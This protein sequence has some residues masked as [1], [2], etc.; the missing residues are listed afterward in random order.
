MLPHISINYEAVFVWVCAVTIAFLQYFLLGR[1]ES[2]TS[3]RKGEKIS[4]YVSVILSNFLISWTLPFGRLQTICLQSF[5]FAATRGYLG[6]SS[7]RNLDEG[8]E[9]ITP[10]VELE[11]YPNKESYQEQAVT[12][13]D[14]SSTGFPY[15]PLAEGQ[16]RLLRFLDKDLSDDATLQFELFHAKLSQRPQYVALS[17]SWG[18]SHEPR[19]VDIVVSGCSHE[20]TRNLVDAL[21]KLRENNISTVWVDAICIN[22]QDAIEKSREVTRMFA[23]YRTAQMVVIWL[24]LDTAP[25]KDMGDLSS[26]IEDIER[27]ASRLQHTP[28]STD[29]SALD[30]LLM[31]PYW[32][33]VWIIQETA[34]AK[35]AR[36]FWGSYIFDLR[37]LETLLRDKPGSGNDHPLHDLARRVLSVRAACRAQQKP[38]LMDI[39]AMTASSSTSVLRDKVYGL[40]GL[41]SDWTDF[42]QEPNYTKEVSENHLCLE[43]TSNHIAWYSSADII[44][45]RSTNRYQAELPSWC[46]DY[47]HFQPHQFDKNLIPYVCGQD[48]NLGWERRRAFGQSSPNMNEIIPDTFVT[49]GSRLI[50]KGRRIGQITA[51]G[52]LLDEEA[53]PH[54]SHAGSLVDE[55]TDRDIGKA[56]RRLLLICHNQTYGI[57]PS[58]AFFSLLYA[59]PDHVYQD[60]GHLRVKQWLNTHRAFFETFGVQLL[61]DSDEYA[62]IARRAGR[63][64]PSSK[65]LPEWKE[66]FSLNEDNTISRRGEH[67]LYPMLQSISSILEERMRLMYIHDQYLLGWAHRDAE[68]GDIVWHLEG[69]SLQAILRKSE[70]LSKEHGESIYTLVGHAYVDPVMASGRWMARESGSRLVNIC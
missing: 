39:L 15:S 54:N 21:H 35:Q 50:L 10:A 64:S 48:A 55:I 26:A 27:P 30:R 37:S 31:Q 8:P 19:G 56:F 63:L 53:V 24:G 57:Q 18:Q 28:S 13:G 11:K 42:V 65:V 3:T 46:P 62:F 40:L 20:V 1:L 49:S 25:E 59:L 34:A 22:Q 14:S 66:F 7:T 4:L 23:I 17:Y 43:M 5:L 61:P 38:R 51:L 45:L 60:R 69:C 44:F 58:S 2:R 52:F 41:A 36:I 16:I 68:P 9:P 32:L 12:V 67:P 47:F 6:R 29:L 70:Q 33:R